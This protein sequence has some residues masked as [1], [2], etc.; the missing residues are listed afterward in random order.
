M[1][2]TEPATMITDYMLSLTCAVFA[3]QTFRL[4]SSHRALPIWMLAFVT[5]SI[6]ALLGGTFHGF[7]LHLTPT[8]AKGIWDF[9]MFLIGASAAFIVAGAIITSVS[10]GEL[11]SVKWIRRGLIVSA[12]GLAIQK[13]GW[14]LHHHFNHND[15]YH[16]IQIAGFW[17][18]FEGVRRLE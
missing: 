2:I 10:R 16:M 6:A 8:I 9:T 11:E 18:L 14:D 12:V 17:C 13:I 5:G 1:K 15:L 4:Q 3:I 7:R